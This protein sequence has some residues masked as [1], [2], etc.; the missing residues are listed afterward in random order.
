L[1]IRELEM[2][3]IRSYEQALIR[4]PLGRTL[5]E[6]DIGSGKSTILMAIE[7]ALFG[8]GSETGAS[9]LKLGKQ[10]GRVR[11]KFEVDGREF[12]VSRGLERRGGRVQQTDGLLTTPEEELNLSPRELKEKVLE[13]LEFNE[14]PDPKAQ[15]LIYR[16]AVYTPQEE[17]KE[18][19]SMGPD[20]RLQ[21]LRRAFR[22]EDYKIAGENASEIGRE[23]RG[24]IR[25]LEG[26][27]TGLERLKLELDEAKKEER[28]QREAVG[29]L[30]EWESEGETALSRLRD[31]RRRL[32]ERQLSLERYR[33][34]KEVQERLEK[35][36]TRSAT[37][38]D[39]E[40]NEVGER[41]SSLESELE[42][43][44]TKGPPTRRT[45]AQ[46]KAE[47]RAADSEV[48]RLA[49]L[50]ATIDS[51]LEE[52]GTI[53]EKGTCPV[54]DRPVDAHDF[55][56]RKASK[57]MERKHASVELEMAEEALSKVRETRERVE[58]YLA[59]R[60]RLADGRAALVHLRKEMR[61]RKAERARAERKRKGARLRL[62]VLEGR[63]REVEEVSA[64]LATLE[65]SVTRAEDALRETGKKL[66]RA[67][68]RMRLLE[69]K[70]AQL[71]TDMQAKEDAGRRRDLLKENETWLSDYFEPTVQLIERSVLATINQE[72]GSLFEKWFEMLVGDPEKEV[73]V[74]EDFT[75][76][77]TQGGYDQDVRYLSGGERTSVA[78][79]YRLA[80]NLVAQRVS[81]G[82]KSNLLVL[83]E[84]TDGFSHE[85]LGN[86]REVLDD[87]GCPQ[88]IVV[89]HDKEL[90][91]FADQIYRVR[92][93]RGRSTVQLA[94]A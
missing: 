25:E 17:M 49:V 45:P 57:E 48:K 9:L 21:T 3:N 10:E 7:F 42:G 52:Y 15:S 94:G 85:Q 55:A 31:E 30:E 19:L 87:V 88:V 22:I 73:K 72:F 76:V 90:E 11:M 43:H 34:E 93:D 32:R 18:I 63:M 74:D 36:G 33:S 60:R 71:R 37:N 53:M 58:V 35:E 75:P 29:S 61:E 89:S 69:K 84:P 27:G 16:Y 92:K 23:L 44:R 8:L 46:L 51:K 14:A 83:D 13:V 28:E 78:L 12:E 62:G 65:E 70:M 59:E 54:C 40:V 26:L 81:I 20:V 6:G 67:G 24:D 50:A 47:E 38:L 5:F 66:A 77:I 2:M 80:L 4:L 86:V 79:A 56:Q 41:I 91:S 1:I 39:R 64:T 68:E 82:M